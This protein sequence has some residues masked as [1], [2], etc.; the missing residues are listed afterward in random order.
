[1][2]SH[3]S[4]YQ[5]RGYHYL[6]EY[7]ANVYNKLTSLT[8]YAIFKVTPQF[9]DYRVRKKSSSH[10][11]VNMVQSNI[12]YMYCVKEHLEFD[13][14]DSNLLQKLILYTNESECTKIKITVQLKSS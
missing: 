7:K 3:A 4:E 10:I 13:M 11:K 6:D 12:S 14:T 9:P 5:F 2:F 1:M 8:L